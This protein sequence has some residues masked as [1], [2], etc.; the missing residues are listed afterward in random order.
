MIFQRLDPRRCLIDPPHQPLDLLSNLCARQAFT[1]LQAH[2]WRSCAQ[3]RLSPAYKRITGEL[4]RKAGFHPLTSAFV[5][6]LVR[7]AGFHPLTSALLEILCARQA[8]T[9]LQAHYCGSCAQGRL[10][11]AYKRIC[12]RSC[13]QGR[14]SPAYKRITGELVRKAGFHPLTSA[15]S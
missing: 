13:A 6:D 8:F 12:W 5:G 7:K 2:C 9:R 14:L 4:V 11:P 15:L 3:G 10:S 1:R